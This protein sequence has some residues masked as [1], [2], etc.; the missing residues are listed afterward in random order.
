MKLQA[1]N[2]KGSRPSSPGVHRPS[3]P[4]LFLIP[5]LRPGA[6]RRAA[7]PHGEDPGVPAGQRGAGGRRRPRHYRVSIQPHHNPAPNPASKP[8]PQ[9][10]AKN[11]APK[12][13]P[14]TPPPNS[15]PK[16]HPQNLAQTSPPKSRPN[17]AHLQQPETQLMHAIVRSGAFRRV[18]PANSQE[19][20]RRNTEEGSL[21]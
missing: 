6:G 4:R 19:T 1:L 3:E 17:H 20:L 10:P 11:P 7:D 16:T 15:A 14:Q 13:R 2:H 12:P 21:E 5:A 18:L 9:T 8:R